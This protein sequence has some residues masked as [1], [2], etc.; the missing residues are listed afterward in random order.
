[1]QGRNGQRDAQG[2]CSNDANKKGEQFAAARLPY[3]HHEF[4]C[5]DATMTKK[6]TNTSPL[7]NP[8]SIAPVTSLGYRNPFGI[9]PVEMVTDVS[10]AL[11]E[12]AEAGK[13]QNYSFPVC[14]VRVL[15]WYL[16]FALEEMEN[17]EAASLY[18]MRIVRNYLI[19]KHK[20]D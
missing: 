11:L 16:H 9:P 15:A 14:T 20:Q 1:L 3:N 7:P 17:S 4:T 18:I 2:F 13:D 5:G 19:P 6:N 10:I 12:I 8:D